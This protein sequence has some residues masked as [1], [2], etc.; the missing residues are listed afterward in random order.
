[1][2][3]RAGLLVGGF[4]GPDSRE[5]ALVDFPGKGPLV[6]LSLAGLSVKN[7]RALKR[8]DERPGPLAVLEVH[9]ELDL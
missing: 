7:D 2:V 6:G 4:A 8:V 5:Q 9:H 3:G 1:M